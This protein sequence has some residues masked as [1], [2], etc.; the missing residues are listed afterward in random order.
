MIIGILSDLHFGYGWGTERQADSF[1]QA[2]EALQK[3]VSKADIVVIAGDLFDTRVPRQE[4]LKEALNIFAR[5]KLTHA[6]KAKLVEIKDHMPKDAKTDVWHAGQISLHAT[7]KLGIPIIAIHGTHDRRGRAQVNPVKI[8]EE[9]GYV[10]QL[11]GQTAVFEQ[12]GE[13]VAITGVSGVPEIYARERFKELKLRPISGATNLLMLHQSLAGFVYMDEDNPTLAVEDLPRGF[14]LI[15]NGHIH[16]SSLNKIHRGMTDLLLCG[17][18]I[19]TQV[20]K[21][22][23][24]I[25][26]KVWFY[27]TAAKKLAEDV[28]ATPR[29]VFYFEL[30]GSGKDYAV[31]RKEISQTI[32][33]L[34]NEKTDKKPLARIR[35]IGKATDELAAT[36]TFS[37]LAEQASEFALLT[38]KNDLSSAEQAAKVKAARD[39]LEER[40][41]IE[42]L[43]MRILR[44]RAQAQKLSFAASELFESLASGELEQAEQLLTEKEGQKDEEK[45]A[46]AEK[47][48]SEAIS[49]L[50]SGEKSAFK[51][52]GAG[53]QKLL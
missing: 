19:T 47:T 51:A 33:S 38:I 13:R 29:R 30:D 34:R 35:I 37:D 3:A 24:Q 1:V 6:S 12:N 52:R 11:D 27:D 2:A 45:Q 8:L 23:S 18:T 49:L 21:G 28:L 40:V 39:L 44:Q 25:P 15:V 20:R 22:E 16:W 17:S 7:H 5:L 50:T 42:E 14:D 36:Q 48:A 32:E 46:E 53:Q 43:G 41:S 31:L 4:V 10:I 9:A 26:K